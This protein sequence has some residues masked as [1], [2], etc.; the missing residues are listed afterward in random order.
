MK[1]TLARISGLTVGLLLVLAGTAVVQP[2]QAQSEQVSDQDIAVHYSLYYEEFKN[3]NFESVLPNL[4]WMIENA[5]Q[6]PRSDD[7]N[8]ERLIE[9]YVGLAENAD[10]EAGRQS[11][12]DSALVW[13][14]ES[15]A[16]MKEHELEFDEVQW[17]I[18]KGRFVQEHAQTLGSEA[19]SIASIYLEAHEMAGCE[20]DPYYLRIVIDDFARRGEKQRA[21]ELT[22]R[23][24]ECYS[25][26][27]E[28]ISYIN[29]VRNSLFTSPEERMEF[30][31]T[32]LEQDPEN[33][34]MAAELFDIYLDLEYRDEAAELGDRLLEMQESARTY[35]RLGELHLQD[36]NIDEAIAYYERALEMPDTPDNVRRDVLFNLGIAKQQEGN[37]AE[38]RRYFRRAL[39][40]DS[41]Y[42]QAYIAIGDLYATAVSNCG[43]F[44]REDRAVYWLAV[45]YYQR[46]KANDPNVAGQADQKIST[47]RRSFPDQEA[48]FFKDWSPGDSYRIDYGCYSWIGEST[49]VKQPN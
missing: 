31:R 25:E 7:R 18:R 22:D 10:D 28:M 29:Q 6:Y 40:I 38:A 24:E 11:Y 8:F 21:V 39:E 12:L 36:G 33:L 41:G 17:K 42:G 19:P 46:A 37:L 2:A 16:L 44:E 5:P 30:L 13:F 26:N 4:K 34:E 48:L 45:D 47:Y 20:V 49:T 23:A 15:V 9:T 32:R 14:D 1:S 3:K 43:S 35:R 27:A